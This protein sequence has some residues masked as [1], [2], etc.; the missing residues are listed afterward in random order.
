MFR[1][2]TSSSVLVSGKQ[3]FARALP[4]KKEGRLCQ[5]EGQTNSVPS[6]FRDPLASS[7]A[8][9]NPQFKSPHSSP[10]SALVIASAT[11]AR[12]RRTNTSK[13]PSPVRFH[14]V[15]TPNST[16]FHTR[17]THVTRAIG[18]VQRLAHKPW[19]TEGSTQAVDKLR[20]LVRGGWILS[21]RFNPIAFLSGCLP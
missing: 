4:L 11:T 20:I 1:G 14:T 10:C 15:S 19:G 8:L 7:A 5:S 17:P 18:L 2:A 6:C 12:L 13:A 9:Q 3:R 21:P 16:T